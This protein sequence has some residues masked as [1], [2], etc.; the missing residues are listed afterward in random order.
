MKGS[1][2]QTYERVVF[3]DAYANLYKYIPYVGKY[4]E[5]DRGL[6]VVGR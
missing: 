5:I 3:T 1:L 6:K 4:K 2:K